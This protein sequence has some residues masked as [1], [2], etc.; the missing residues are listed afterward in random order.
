MRL[1]MLKYLEIV[2]YLHML[3]LDWSVYQ[4]KRFVIVSLTGENQ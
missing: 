3:T 1:S 2:H 4:I